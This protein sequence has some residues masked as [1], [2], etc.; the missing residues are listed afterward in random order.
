M[1]GNGLGD[2]RAD[3]VLAK[4]DIVPVLHPG[5]LRQLST[6]LQLRYADPHPV[7]EDYQHL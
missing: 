1:E 4:G 3:I 5:A 6:G 7:R 2:R